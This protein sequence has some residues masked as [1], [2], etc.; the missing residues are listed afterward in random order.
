MR[1]TPLICS[2]LNIETYHESM[3]LLNHYEIQFLLVSDSLAATKSSLAS[4]IE[5]EALVET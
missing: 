5:I 4:S 1:V 2:S 3:P